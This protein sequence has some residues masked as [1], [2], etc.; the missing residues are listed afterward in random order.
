M[1]EQGNTSNKPLGAEP[2]ADQLRHNLDDARWVWSE[3]L[4][5]YNLHAELAS[6]YRTGSRDRKSIA[7]LWE[8]IEAGEYA[9]RAV[10]IEL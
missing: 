9:L 6:L 8:H 5:V 7:N 4:R 3:S 10:G 2:T 1:G